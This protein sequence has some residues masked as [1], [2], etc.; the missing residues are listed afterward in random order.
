MIIQYIG[1]DAELQNFKKIMMG[2]ASVTSNKNDNSGL[3]IY[4]VPSIAD[5]YRIPKRFELPTYFYVTTQDKAVMSRIKEYGINGVFFPPLKAEGV[6]SKLKH[7]MDRADD[8]STS[9]NS[10]EYDLMRIKI[11]AKAENIPPLPDFARQ[12]IAVTRKDSATIAEVTGKIKKDQGMSS[13]VIK[14]VNSPFYGMR[15]EISSI[16]RAT[17]LLGFNSVKNIALA[18][19]LDQ[20]FQKPFN[21]YGTTGKAIWQHSYKVACISQEIGKE[22]GLDPDALYM[23]G[24]MHDIGKVVMMDFL[25]KQ[26]VYIEDER[27][28]LGFDHAEIGGIILNKWSVS[29]QICE[30]VKNHHNFSSNTAFSKI[31]FYANKIDKESENAETIVDEMA[32]ML[33]INDT[34]RLKNI[35]V[36]FVQDANAE[37]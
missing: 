10:E 2:S 32:L 33:G 25:V 16:D 7:A 24:L 18:L 13:K 1:S 22:L 27:R 3:V 11:L 30:A 28:Q 26:V 23:V 6:L 17:V 12:L 31:I 4:E 15:Q 20:Y 34:K 9:Y 14:L 29:P 19:S 35:I 5:L 21:M 37:I 8:G 36:P